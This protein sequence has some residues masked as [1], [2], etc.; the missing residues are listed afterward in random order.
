MC[1]YVL[2]TSLVLVQKNTRGGV[3]VA[4]GTRCEEGRSVDA[5]Q[6]GRQIHEA[7]RPR[8]YILCNVLLGGK[9]NG[10]SVKSTKLRTPGLS[11]FVRRYS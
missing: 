10:K 11:R 4:S 7:G 6:P 5:V 1:L 3:V 9:K 8:G 2:R